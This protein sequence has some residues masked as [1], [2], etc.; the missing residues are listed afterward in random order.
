MSNDGAE[1]I[2]EAML[3]QILCA[4][5]PESEMAAVEEHLKNC[6]YCRARLRALQQG[7]SGVSAG[8]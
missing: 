7:E 2:S 5:V 1:H 8:G 6:A 3:E 4:G